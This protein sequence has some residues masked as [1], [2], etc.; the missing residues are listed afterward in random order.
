MEDI[1]AGR[2]AGLIPR[3]LSRPAWA[4]KFDQP[5]RAA[6]AAHSHEAPGISLRAEI[7]NLFMTCILP[8]N[9]TNPR[10]AIES[11]GA[12]GRASSCVKSCSQ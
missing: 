5:M 2:L 10:S 11:T 6:P 3:P 8:Y 9:W 7:S 12:E 4:G 1:G